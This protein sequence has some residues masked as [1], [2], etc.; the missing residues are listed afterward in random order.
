M[1]ILR[2]F[3]IKLP[4]STLVWKWW[5]MLKELVGYTSST[6]LLSL[7]RKKK[8]QFCKKKHS[9]F[10][11]WLIMVQFHEICVINV[12]NWFLSIIIVVIETKITWNCTIPKQS[13]IFFR[14]ESVAPPFFGTKKGP[15]S[16]STPKALISG[17]CGKTGKVPEYCR[18]RLQILFCNFYIPLQKL[19]SFY[20]AHACHT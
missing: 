6:Y 18:F 16:A 4:C 3:P 5:D 1:N 11:S 7:F 10:I 12:M 19:K 14:S 15:K 20:R 8:L 9:C 13:N 17:W 2:N